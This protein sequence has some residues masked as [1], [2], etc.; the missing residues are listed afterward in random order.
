MHLTIEVIAGLA[1][2]LRALVSAICLA[3]ELGATLHV[4]WSANDPAC[5]AKFDTLFDI[6]SLPHWVRVDMGPL[7]GSS[8]MVLTPSDLEH[9]LSQAPHLPMRSYGHFYQKDP[10]RWVRTLR[11]IKPLPLI[12]QRLL[13][14]PGAIGVHIRRGDHTHAKKHS[15]LSAFVDRMQTFPPTTQFVVATDSLSEKA[16]L[17]GVFGSRL[18]F[19]A[20]SI[21]RMTQKGIEDALLDFLM[22]SRCPL[23]L[24]SYASSFS[25]LAALYGNKTLEVIKTL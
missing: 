23:I 13:D 8:R 3:D 7:D 20:T 22:L 1:N 6:S 11:S 24:G 19:P 25:E 4:I 15:P 5:M 12:A 9:Y 18:T 14:R 17:E 2:R 16:V 21:S 10:E